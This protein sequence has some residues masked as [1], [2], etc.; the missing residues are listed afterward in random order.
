[1]DGTG[2]DP[3]GDGLIAIQENRLVVIGQSDDFYIP[4]DVLVID[5]NGGTILPGILNA[6][7]HRVSTAA[8]RRHL[9][10]LDGVTSV[11]DLGAPLLRMGDFDQ[12]AIQSGPAA[13]VFKAGPM[14]TPPGGYPGLGMNYKIQEE[15]EAAS[16]VRD[17]HARGVDYIKVAL[18][19]GPMQNE[20]FPVL[21]LEELQ[22]IV[23][24]AH[25]LGLLVRAHVYNSAMLEIALDAGVDVIEHL[26]L[27]Y[28]SQDHLVSFFD[29]TGEFRM[30]P[31]LEAHY[32]QMIDQGIVLVPTL[33]VNTRD[34]KVWGD[35]GVSWDEFIQVNLNVISY[36]HMAGGK[37][38]IGN[39]YGVPGIKPGIPLREMDLLQQAGLS[40]QEIIEAATRQAAYVCGQADILGT[41]EMGKLADLIIVTGNPLADINALDSVMY[42]IKNG[43]IVVS[44]LEGG[45]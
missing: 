30:P 6:H 8:T 9:F 22:S 44:P 13:R 37:I 2:A 45:Q 43:E 20:Y 10:L 21:K 26:P 39:D 11:C 41:L 36:F 12:E 33:E 40:S 18:E 5:A 32:I 31:E 14:I 24:T 4:D 15:D 25:A 29:E 35:L 3:I 42:V 38:A 34:E 17:L 7:A 23:T 1:M 16:A 28:D 19:P 27:Q